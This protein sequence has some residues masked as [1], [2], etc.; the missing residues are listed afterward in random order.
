MPI[1][2]HRLRRVLAMLGWLLL[3]GLIFA[4]LA[5]IEWRPRLVSIGPD[6]ERFAAYCLFAF[7]ITLAYP[8]WRWPIL[9]AGLL[10]ILSLEAGQYITASRH[11]RL[12]DALVKGAGFLCGFGLAA[13]LERLAHRRQQAGSN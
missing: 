13:A 8:R 3:A 12:M 11:G 2:T 7:C 10:F 1:S 4:T 9:V 5:P 6:T